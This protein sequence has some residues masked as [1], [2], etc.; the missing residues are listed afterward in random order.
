[1]ERLQPTH[2]VHDC[3]L[4]VDCLDWEQ[5]WAQ[6]L[7]QVRATFTFNV[8]VYVCLVVCY[9][10]VFVRNVSTLHRG[11]TVCS[12]GRIHTRQSQTLPM[13]SLPLRYRSLP[14]LSIITLVYVAQK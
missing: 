6:C 1:M 4:L 7:Y 14:V 10:D 2:L 11:V 13:V 8:C 12:G 3:H 9:V 5:L